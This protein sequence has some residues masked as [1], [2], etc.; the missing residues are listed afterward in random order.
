[1][2]RGG[3]R[4]GAGAPRG[5]LNALKTGAHSRR[6][7]TVITALLANPDTRAVLLKLGR[8]QLDGN[9][10]FRDVIVASARLLYDHP[11]SDELQATVDR[12]LEQQTRK[13]GPRHAARAAR[14]FQ[15]RI[16]VDDLVRSRT[17][18]RRHN[19]IFRA[20]F[21][22]LTGGPVPASTRPRKPAEPHP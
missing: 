9:D 3:R 13:L 18:S 11:L 6:A 21:E 22:A 10:P 14:D 1:M 2:P 15:R 16:G 20:F 8:N 4:P 17:A 12:I 5:N 19:K 7:R